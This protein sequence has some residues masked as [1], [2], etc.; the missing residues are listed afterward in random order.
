MN[1]MEDIAKLVIEEVSEELK[2]FDEVSKPKA[3]SEEPKIIKKE[4]SVAVNA[5]LEEDEQ[6]FISSQKI[7]LNNLKERLE[8]LFEGLKSAEGNHNLK[9]KIT[10]NFLEYLL[11]NVEDKI[12]KIPK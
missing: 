11:A 4:E 2:N 7:F 3:L 5:N 9:L 1:N 8:V 10:I 6:E 12:T